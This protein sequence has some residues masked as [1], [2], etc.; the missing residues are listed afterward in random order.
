MTMSSPDRILLDNIQET[1]KEIKAYTANEAYKH[2]LKIESDN[3]YFEVNCNQINKINLI[4]FSNGSILQLFLENNRRA[5]FLINDNF[6]IT[7]T[8]EI[9]DVITDNPELDN[10]KI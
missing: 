3:F 1:I 6:M 9:S 4:T 5:E 8:K 10:L 7:N 2:L